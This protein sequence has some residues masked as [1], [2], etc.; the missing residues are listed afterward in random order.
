MK[1]FL[2]EFNKAPSA[3][4]KAVVIAKS[5]QDAI[6]IVKKEEITWFNKTRSLNH[7]G[8]KKIEEIDEEGI[9]YIGYHCC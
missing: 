5:V 1:A 6:S 9:A 7:Y 3:P 2:I 8:I 4:E